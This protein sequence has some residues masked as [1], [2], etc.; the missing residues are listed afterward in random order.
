MPNS[1]TWHP[2]SSG[3]KSRGCEAQTLYGQLFLVSQPLQRSPGK[4]QIN[5]CGT[6][7]YRRKIMPPNFSPRVLKFKIRDISL[8]VKGN[9]SATAG[10]IRQSCTWFSTLNLFRPRDNS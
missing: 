10:K 7:W 9:L 8:Q 4:K 2:S 1:N 6:V 5:C 3:A